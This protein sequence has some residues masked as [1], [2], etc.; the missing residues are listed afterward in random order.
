[1]STLID[2]DRRIEQRRR[3]KRRRLDESGPSV[4]EN[5]SDAFVALDRAWRY[6]YVNRAAE[7]LIR[8][9]REEVLGRAVWEIF[10]EFV[11]TR[12]ESGYR[13]AMDLGTIVQLVEYYEPL[14]T[15][16]E[17]TV[18][19]SPE[20]IA[21]YTRDITERKQAE[22][23]IAKSIAELELRVLDRTAQLLA[24][25]EELERETAKRNLAEGERNQ[26]LRRLMAAQEDERNRISRQ[27]HDQLGQDLIALTLKLGMLKGKYGT[28]AEL[29]E[30]LV[31]LEAIA[32]QIS[33]DVDFLVWELRPTAIED[34]GLL[35]AL[36][37][38]VE[39]WSKHFDVDAELHISG[40][41]NDKLSAEAETVIYR[42]VQEALTNIAKHAKASNVSVLLE[43]RSDQVSLIIEDNGVGFDVEES[44]GQQPKGV[45]L[46][47]MRERV[48]LV[49]GTAE[50]ESNA[51][52]GTTVAVRIPFKLAEV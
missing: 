6:T 34:L 5:M 38:Y 20:G 27:L 48:M 4:L 36:S 49:G 30:K 40:E 33:R 14:N 50:I 24:A 22:A 52:S 45:G 10:P 26:L 51:G 44:F 39:N 37:N 18:C 28:Q 15:W 8:R 17:D 32:R 47:G 46:I 23:A 13:R 43:W 25:S 19:P 31:A 41:D 7:K 12:F 42:V 16:F 9:R 29:V 35:V 21:V 3:T 1:M 11:G 2:D